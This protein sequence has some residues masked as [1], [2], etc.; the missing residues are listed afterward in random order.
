MNDTYHKRHLEKSPKPVREPKK[1][2]GSKTPKTPKALKA[3][4]A[5]CP[6]AARCG[7]CQLGH[8]TYPEQL[9]YKQ[10]KVEKLLGKLCK[11][12][13]ILGMADPHHYRNKVHAVI[14]TDRDKRPISGVYA[15][16]T[17]H[18]VPVKS[19]PRQKRRERY[20]LG[21]MACP[22]GNRPLRFMWRLTVVSALPGKTV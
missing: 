7:G 17:H 18:V 13:P 6:V 10:Q 14:G 15:M 12:E 22:A 3:P 20:F 5:H 9:E 4:Q 16:G 19:C 11:V 8:L 21:P 2:N 1:E